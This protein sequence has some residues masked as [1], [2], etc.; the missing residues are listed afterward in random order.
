MNG[1]QIHNWQVTYVVIAALFAVAALVVSDHLRVGEPPDARTRTVAAATA[2]ALWPV[3]VV[4][5]VQIYVIRSA[6]GRRVS[7]AGAAGEAQSE[8]ELAGVH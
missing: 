7:R 1:M 8:R 4:G 5:M 2:G 3:M 6:F